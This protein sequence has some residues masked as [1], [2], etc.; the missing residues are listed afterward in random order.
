MDCHDHIPTGKTFH[1]LADPRGGDAPRQ[2]YLITR[3]GAL[4]V[5]VDPGRVGA[6]VRVEP[7]T[8]A[9][10]RRKRSEP[11]E[12]KPEKGDGV[13]QES[14]KARVDKLYP[15]QRAAHLAP[16]ENATRYGKGD[17]LHLDRPKLL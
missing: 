17:P 9:K 14:A 3:P 6:D 16:E 4:A 5:H 15:Q 7:D 2:T 10:V 13:R 11:P 8:R 1:L 12:T